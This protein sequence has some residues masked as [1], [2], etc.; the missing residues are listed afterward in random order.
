VIDDL[1]LWEV[2]DGEP[3]TLAADKRAHQPAEPW[4]ARLQP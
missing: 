4:G 1:N 3:D 2:F